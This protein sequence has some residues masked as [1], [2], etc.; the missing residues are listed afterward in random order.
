M[1]NLKLKEYLLGAGWKQSAA[2]PCIFIYRTTGEDGKLALMA[3]Y[4]DDLLLA[5]ACLILLA[6][7]KAEIMKQFRMTD[8]GPIH[9]ILGMKIDYTLG[10]SMIISHKPYLI[11]LVS[12]FDMA[13]ANPA[14][15]PAD[16][17]GRLVKNDGDCLP[18]S[19]IA[20]YQAMVGSLLYAAINTRPDIAY[21]VS[22]VS[23]FCSNPMEAHVT[24]FTFRKSRS[25]FLGTLTRT[26]PVTKTTASQRL[27]TCSMSMGIL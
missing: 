4:V 7:L 5:A 14:T 21:A 23:K 15:T 27:A 17:N 2:D 13:N 20:K 16:P 8:G 9:F 18:N 24:A 12:T 10:L 11:R 19:E 26:G 6:R 3:V 22:T 25:L 1:W